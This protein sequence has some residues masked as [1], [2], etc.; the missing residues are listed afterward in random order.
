MTR[1]YDYDEAAKEL[2]CEKRWLQ[3]NIK[4]LPHSKKGRVVTFTQDDIDRIDAMHHHEPETTESGQSARL[5]AV[6]PHPLAELKP[7]PARGTARQNA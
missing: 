1:R 5:C 3:R 7:L 2:K 6:G 4:R